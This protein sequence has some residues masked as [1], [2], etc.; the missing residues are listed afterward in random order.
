MK[1]YLEFKQIQAEVYGGPAMREGVHRNAWNMPVLDKLNVFEFASAPGMHQQGAIEG[2]DVSLCMRLTHYVLFQ[3]LV[4]TQDW[5]TTNHENSSFVSCV[6]LRNMSSIS[7]G[8]LS[9]LL[10]TCCDK[11]I[12]PANGGQLRLPVPSPVFEEQNHEATIQYDCRLHVDTH[13]HKMRGK[14]D[15]VLAVSARIATNKNWTLVDFSTDESV[16]WYT[17]TERLA[18]HESSNIKRPNNRPWWSWSLCWNREGCVC[19]LLQDL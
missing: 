2:I 8:C 9:L 10:H 7:L 3:G 5:S 18:T 4:M 15:N 14:S 19:L 6:H 16:L 13:H 12:I 17:H 1:Q 11:T